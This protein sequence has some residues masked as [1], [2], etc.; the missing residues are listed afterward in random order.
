[1]GDVQPLHTYL[2]W[3]TR[4]PELDRW[5]V[6]NAIVTDNLTL[7]TALVGLQM[8]DFSSA[9]GA[10]GIEYTTALGLAVRYRRLAMVSLLVGTVPVDD[11]DFD[12]ATPLYI[13]TETD[14][15]EIAIM[16]ISFGADVNFA[17]A[18]VTPF[19]NAVYYENVG[20]AAVML[21]NGADAEAAYGPWTVLAVAVHHDNIPLAELIMR[22]LPT[23]RSDL[24]FLISVAIDTPR[25]LAFLANDLD[26]ETY[27]AT[28]HVRE[29]IYRGSSRALD[30]FAP[31]TARGPIHVTSV[32]PQI[33]RGWIASKKRESRM[34]R[35]MARRLG[36]DLSR[37]IQS[38]LVPRWVIK[39]AEG[40]FITLV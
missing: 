21:A 37:V 28:P 29:A 6:Q 27:D 14:Q 4:T 7:L 8:V 16:L 32:Y 2:K 33:V 10:Y 24:E 23:W 15:D 35:L 39:E 25:M 34:A 38:L 40:I 12:G 11:A 18:G 31:F 5:W 22:W 9:Y 3:G 36:D 30:F 13:A 1:M 19:F 17:R 20:L 26:R